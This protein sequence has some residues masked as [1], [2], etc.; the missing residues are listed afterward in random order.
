[1]IAKITLILGAALL[2][3]AYFVGVALVDVVPDAVSSVYFFHDPDWR[4]NSP[5]VFSILTT[6]RFA[7]QQGL[8]YQYLG[9]WIPEC[10]SLAYK[11]NYHP[12]ERLAFYPEDDEE[13]V[14]L[15]PNSF[16]SNE[17]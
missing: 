3:A 16:E 8:N 11:S 10:Q 17:R 15:S 1:M 13:P 5:G 12:H 6:A 4:Q 14:W 7:Q 2:L 9:S